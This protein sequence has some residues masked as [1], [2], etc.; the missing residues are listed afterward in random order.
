M[1]LVVQ[2]RGSVAPK[3]ELTV[4]N[5]FFVV[6]IGLDQRFSLELVDVVLDGLQVGPVLGADSGK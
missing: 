2:Q 4:E 1:R 5:A 6:E 3:L